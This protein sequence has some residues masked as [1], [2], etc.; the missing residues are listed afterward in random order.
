[1]AFQNRLLYTVKATLLER[2]TMGFAMSKC[3]YRFLMKLSLQKRR[4]FQQ[5]P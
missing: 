2:K 3:S 1:M 4:G 5:L